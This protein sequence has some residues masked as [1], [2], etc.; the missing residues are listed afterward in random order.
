VGGPAPTSSPPPPH[1]YK[2]AFKA[3][4]GLPSAEAAGRGEL[5]PGP[6]QAHSGCKGPHMVH[7]GQRLQGLSSPVSSWPATES[8]CLWRRGRVVAPPTLPGKEGGRGYNRRRRHKQQAASRPPQRKAKRERQTQEKMIRKQREVGGTTPKARRS[9]GRSQG[10]WC[11]LSGV[12]AAECQVGTL[13][14]CF[15]R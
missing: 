7:P 6:P 11:R 15:T 2:Q 3:A 1:L 13:V 5:D 12:G 9:H 8:Q 14:K 10:H 4:Q